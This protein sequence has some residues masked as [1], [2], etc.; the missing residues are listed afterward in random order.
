MSDTR[1]QQIIDTLQNPHGRGTE[2]VSVYVPPERSISDVSA[3]LTDEY[4]QASN[5][6]SKRT[7]TN[8]QSALKS[9]KSR[10]KYYETVP[11]NGLALFSGAIEDDGG[12]TSVETTV[13]D[14]LP[15]A[16][17]SFEYRCGSEFYTE[18]L[19]QMLSQGPTYGLLVLDKRDAHVGRLT[20]ARIDHLGHIDSLVPGKHKAGGQS[21]Q[22]FARL[23]LDAINEFYKKVAD[24][25]WSAF[26]EDRHDL[27]GVLVGG[28]SPSKDEFL[29]GEY[30]HHEL[31]DAIVG[32]VDVSDTTERGLHELVERGESQLAA[33]E[34]TAERNL[35]EQF[36]TALRDGE[37]VAYGEADVQRAVE[38]GAVDTLLVSE[39]VTREYEE[40]ADAAREYGGTVEEISEDFERGDQLRRAFDGVAA[41]L[42]YEI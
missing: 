4:G 27:D 37:P 20:G 1:L 39:S 2:L 26:G 28:P 29:D 41:L 21:Q 19:E 16:I 35:V 33:A 18:P 40:L 6:K 13:L 34:V 5:I 9:L 24:L 8:V 30:L 17:E 32:V 14:D 36:F 42:R 12:Q 7:R 31:Q 11:D 25:A 10:I 38:Y 23:R 22:R 3:T 15:A